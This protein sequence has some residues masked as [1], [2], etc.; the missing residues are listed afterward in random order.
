MTMDK[1]I[2]VDKNPVVCNDAMKWGMWFQNSKERIVKQT[3]IDGIKVSTV[4]LGLD[5][6]WGDGGEPLLFETMIFGGQHDQFQE[7]YSTWD[8]AEAG[9]HKAC[10]MILE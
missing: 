3:D 5:H 4:F 6:N 8:E 1:Y 7:R 2:L 10:A 9:H